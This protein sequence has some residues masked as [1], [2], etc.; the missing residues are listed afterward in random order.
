MHL[1]PR[2]CVK[3]E[4]GLL[5]TQEQLEVI[6]PTIPFSPASSSTGK[7]S[8]DWPHLAA[9][10]MTSMVITLDF[11]RM[12][13]E[14]FNHCSSFFKL[15]HHIRFLS[16]LEG[17][18]W[19]ARS[20]NE[21]QALRASLRV[22]AFMRFPESPGRLPNLLDQEVSSASLLMHIAVKVFADSDSTLHQAAEP[23]VK[24]YFTIVTHRYMDLDDTLFTSNPVSHD[25]VTAYKPAVL[26]GLKG[27]CAISPQ[28]FRNCLSWL[29][30][31][32]TRLVVCS[33]REIRLALQ[34]LHSQLLIPST[35]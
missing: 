11:I 32:I 26:C 23:Y 3:L 35:A 4:W 12:I 30:P 17:V 21:D 25:L 9:S 20:F 16:V 22:R 7:S 18:H 13:R 27:L 24:R 34:L 6:R 19:H 10:A 31:L 2:K 33:D 28:Q 15:R 5:F 1:K 14:F 29:G 8:E